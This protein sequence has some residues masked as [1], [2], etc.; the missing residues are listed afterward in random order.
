MF[1]RSALAGVA[2]NFQLPAGICFV[3]GAGEPQEP[4]DCWNIDDEIPREWNYQ[5][6]EI[7]QVKMKVNRTP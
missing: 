4:Q 5:E 2:G 3:F 1:E 7:V 6:S